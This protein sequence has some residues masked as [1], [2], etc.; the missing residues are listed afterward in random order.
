MLY[1]VHIAD[2]SPIA[3]KQFPKSAWKMFFFSTGPCMICVQM[4]LVAEGA[5]ALHE[6][7]S[8][9]LLF[10]SASWPAI[11]ACNFVMV[12]ANPCWIQQ[13]VKDLSFVKS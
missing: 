13:S 5:V 10:L 8:C 1:S 6:L 11:V 7:L 2:I 9:I 3:G 12:T 4:C